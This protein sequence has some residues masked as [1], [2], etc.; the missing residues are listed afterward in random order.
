VHFPCGVGTQTGI[1]RGVRVEIDVSIGE[2]V[3]ARMRAEMT[4]RDLTGNWRYIALL[5]SFARINFGLPEL[6]FT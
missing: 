1:C 6:L 2:L 4:M 3:V 5:L